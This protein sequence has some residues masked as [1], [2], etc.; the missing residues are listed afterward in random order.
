MEFLKNYLSY[1]EFSRGCGKNT[2]LAYETDLRFFGDFFS[3]SMEECKREDVV[4]YFKMLRQR[5]FESN[6]ISRK[7]VSIRLFFRFLRREKLISENPT[8]F[9]KSYKHRK[10]LPIFLYQKEVS[11]LL[12]EL[13]SGGYVF[14]RDKMIFEM[15]YGLALRISE[16]KQ[17][18]EFSLVENE[19]VMRILGKGNKT[20]FVPI[21]GRLAIK[22]KDFLEIRKFFFLEKKVDLKKSSPL[23]LNLRGV[24]LS[25]RGIRFLFYRSLEKIDF[26]NKKNI[27]PH[28]LRHSLATHLLENG[29]DLKKIQDLLGH[30]SLSTTQKYTHIS[31]ERLREKYL[32]YHPLAM[33]S[34]E[35][36]KQMSE[37]IAGEK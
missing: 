2:L 30:S 13:P 28:S 6:S 22:L 10:K 14:E 31:K 21:T 11:H 12:S 3:K 33:E 19:S 8:L 27:Y 32:K 1:L 20:R 35:Q 37:I 4:R 24:G 23:F 29:C 25:V 7:M 36:V 34:G 15:L 9:L 26:E 16:L 5:K 17:L 18:S